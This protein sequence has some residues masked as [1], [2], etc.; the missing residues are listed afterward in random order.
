MATDIR[1]LILFDDTT[2]PQS[3][4]ERDSRAFWLVTADL[5]FAS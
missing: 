3:I 2:A 1:S 4:A 5:L